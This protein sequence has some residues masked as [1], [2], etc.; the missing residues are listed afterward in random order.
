VKQSQWWKV[1]GLIGAVTAIA[2]QLNWAITYQ[3]I[4]TFDPVGIMLLVRL[5]AA[6]IGGPVGLILLRRTLRSLA[7]SWPVDDCARQRYL[8]RE[9]WTYLAF[10]G[11]VLG[12]T[13]WS[14][15]AYTLLAIGAALFAAGQV[16]LL[17]AP[18]PRSPPVG[19]G[20]R[21]AVAG[22]GWLSALFF[23]SG[24][25][26]LI[27][28]VVWQRALMTAL[29]TNIESITV[30][31]SVFM[32]GLGAGAL[33]GGRL[34]RRF[35]N[36]LPHLFVLIELAIGVFG[37]FSLP[38]LHLVASSVVQGSL[39]AVACSVYGLL[40]VPTLLM[41]ATLPI[42]STHLYRVSGNV[43]RTVGLLYFVNTLGSAFASIF[44]ANVLFVLAGLE[45][46][47]YVAVACN[48]AVALLALLAV[49][50][51]PS[52]AP[53][54]ASS[55]SEH[56]R[57]PA[58]LLLALALAVG[59]VS[60]SQEILW[61]RLIGYATGSAPEVF[62]NVLGAFLLGLALGS[63]TG[64]RH[65]RRPHLHV[66]LIGGLLVVAAGVVFFFSAPLIALFR[67]RNYG[68]GA[69]QLPR[70]LTTA[71]L[72]VALVAFLQGGLLPMLCHLADREGRAVG[73]TVSWIY[74]ANIIGSVAGPLL[75]GFLMLDHWRVEQALLAV[76]VLTVFVGAAMVT[77]FA[78]STAHR[79]VAWG[80]TVGLVIGL[81]ALC[82][83]VSDRL[84]EKLQ[85]WRRDSYSKTIQ[86]RSGIIAIESQETSAD[87]IYGHGMY[88]GRFNVDPDNNVNGIERAYLIAALHAAPKD[89]LEIGLSTG[90]WTRVM[91][92]YQMVEHLTV[93]EINRGYLQ[94]VSEYPAQAAI[95]HHP[96]VEVVVDDGRRWLN[97]NPERKFDFVVMNTTYHWRSQASNVL[98]REFIGHVK[99]HLKPGGVLF[100]NTTASRAVTY[101]AAQEFKHIVEYWNFIAVSDSPIGVS[102]EQRVKN[103]Q[104]FIRDD[105]AVFGDGRGQEMLAKIRDLPLNDVAASYRPPPEERL[106]ITD[107]NMATEFKNFEERPIGIAPFLVDK[108]RANGGSWIGALTRIYGGS[109]P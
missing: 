37:S 103:L 1:V 55:G 86:T 74:V 8:H 10:L 70:G 18:C 82:R 73:V 32:F 65:C 47:V 42:L 46:A 108:D 87:T 96:R 63:A 45:T 53:T 41:G 95:L 79:V 64:R 36:H 60:L 94:A 75:T 106:V 23:V 67:E 101:T 92:D 66:Y 57:R 11:P 77:P 78:R 34:S 14:L 9:G 59:F 27:Y 48:L 21:A 58:L 71:Y 26:A 85:G 102:P 25:A 33:L 40:C 72:C 105:K 7:T 12:A 17:L 49:R 99:S 3:P 81:V 61:M 91:A 93:I 90:S 62:A 13:G 31:V 50:R 68:G 16:V 84:L 44:T 88:D 43:G 6:G 20:A 98:S 76:S 39:G 52:R 109:A 56:V 19:P 24:G 51:A 69:P 22:A 83:P 107:A 54:A 104:R 35:P 30:I 97:R 5:V 15:G 29:G 80:A 4:N 2:T 38:L 100:Y 28:Q 89:V